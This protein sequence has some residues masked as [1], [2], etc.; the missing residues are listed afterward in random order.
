MGKRKKGDRWGMKGRRA[1]KTV[2]GRE[3]GGG[4]EKRSEGGRGRKEREGGRMGNLKGRLWWWWRLV[5]THSF[6]F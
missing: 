5:L 2:E 1:L 3:K 4:E 6:V